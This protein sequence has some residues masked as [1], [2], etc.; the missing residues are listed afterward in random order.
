MAEVQ[1]AGPLAEEVVVGAPLGEE[2]QRHAEEEANAA[3]ADHLEQE[4][5]VSAA[6]L[7]RRILGP[8]DPRRMELSKEERDWALD[9]K[10]AV[11]E[12]AELNAL[13][14]FQ[15]AQ[16]AIIHQD[17][18]G[19]AL[20]AAEVLQETRKDYDILETVP[21]AQKRIETLLQLSPGMNVSFS[22][23]HDDGCY[24][25]VFDYAK[26]DVQ[27]LNIADNARNSVAGG[28]YQLQSFSPDLDSVRKGSIWLVEC[29][30]YHWIPQ[31]GD[32]KFSREYWTVLGGVYP[33]RLQAYKCFHTPVLFNVIK[34]MIRPWV[35]KDIY[36]II[37]LGCRSPGRL[38]SFYMIPTGEAANQRYLKRIL[39]ALQRRYEN[40][41]NFRL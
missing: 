41:R 32:L 4:E 11:Q 8:T 18:I 14:D 2:I 7:L 3:Q 24:V 37:Q 33:F 25:C 1:P 40:E 28:Y 15:Y 17:D 5:D 39:E 21:D 30:G 29:D 23:S 13:T 19:A 27:K 34:S 31:R 6:F 36:G 26:L 9:I 35:P 20:E 16:M 22:F 12:T 38:D 10:D